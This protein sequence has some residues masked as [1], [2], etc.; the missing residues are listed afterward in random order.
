MLLAC[1]DDQAPWCAQLES[2]ADLPALAE[3]ISNGDTDAATAEVDRFTAVASD[4]PREIRS[5]MESVADALSEA[6]GVAMTGEGADPDELELRREA[7]NQQLGRVTSDVAAV[8]DWAEQA[9]GIR[10]D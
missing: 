9:C 7:V 10:L 6:V 1:G 2:V 4:A 8:S 5:E 3:A